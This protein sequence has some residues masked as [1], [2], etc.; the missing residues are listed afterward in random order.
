MLV[1]DFTFVL[2]QF[3]VLCVQFLG[4]PLLLL[5]IVI[6]EL[7]LRAD[8]QRSATERSAAAAVNV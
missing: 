8:Q 1:N 4:I 6:D 7:L 5:F 3:T 2:V